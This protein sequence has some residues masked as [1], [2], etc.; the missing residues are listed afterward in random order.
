LSPP[1]SIRENGITFQRFATITTATTTRTIRLRT[2]LHSQDVVAVP[3]CRPCRIAKAP[4]WPRSRMARNQSLR[5]LNL[6]N[7]A[8][9][10]SGS[11]S[12]S[13]RARITTGTVATRAACGPTNRDLRLRETRTIGGAPSRTREHAPGA[14]TRSSAVFISVSRIRPEFVDVEPP[15]EN[16][17]YSILPQDLNLPELTADFD[18]LILKVL[19][20]IVDRQ[21]RN[22]LAQQA[23]YYYAIMN[24]NGQPSGP[25]TP[26]DPHM[27]WSPDSH[28]SDPPT[29]RHLNL[30]S[31]DKPGNERSQLWNMLIPRLAY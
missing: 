25:P 10:A 8:P 2:P 16:R 21:N 14:I 22:Y 5:I 31:L 13:G 30:P 15:A 17:R 4:Q 28:P 20:A 6:K 12:L 3:L 9:R 11:H 29:P 18:Y 26:N 24:L 7:R 19:V 1:G 27:V 23:A